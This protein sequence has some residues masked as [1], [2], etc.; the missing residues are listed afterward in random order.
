MHDAQQAG[1]ITAEQAEDAKQRY[2]QIPR[3]FLEAMAREKALLDQAITLNVQLLVGSADFACMFAQQH[4]IR[5]V[6]VLA[7]LV[8]YD[9]VS[10]TCCSMRNASE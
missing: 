1:E 10:E 7:H 9:P 6:A 4:G 3:H 5:T 2:A 8:W